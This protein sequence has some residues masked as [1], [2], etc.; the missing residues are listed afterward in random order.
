MHSYN[1]LLYCAWY[2]SS[3]FCKQCNKLNKVPARTS[4]YGRTLGSF[5]CIES[6]RLFSLKPKWTV[7]HNCYIMAGVMWLRWWAY[8]GFNFAYHPLHWIRQ[9]VLETIHMMRTMLFAVHCIVKFSICHSVSTVLH[10]EPCT[11]FV[12]GKPFSEHSFASW[13]LHVLCFRETI[14]WAQFCTM[15]LARALFPGNH[16]VS[17]VLH[18]EPC[19][20][21]VSWKPFSEHIIGFASWTLHALCSGKPLDCPFDNNRQEMKGNCRLSRKRIF[22]CPWT[23]NKWYIMKGEYCDFPVTNITRRLPEYYRV[24]KYADPLSSYW[25]IQQ[26]WNCIKSS[27]MPWVCLFYFPVHHEQ[28]TLV[29]INMASALSNATHTDVFQSKLH[30]LVDYMLGGYMMI[31]GMYH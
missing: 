11:C 20:C 18:H 19:T 1:C 10:H 26:V 2:S 31:V 6:I 23:C 8:N 7:A 17:T 30:P 22:L 12:S 4:A 28:R 25:I 29:I 9:I 16:S 14:Q 13:T 24:R 21:F 5:L 27:S 15:N 3:I